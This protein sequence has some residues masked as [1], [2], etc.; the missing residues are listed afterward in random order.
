MN[1][2][3]CLGNFAKRW[4][5]L[6]GYHLQA[7]RPDPDRALPPVAYPLVGLVMG[8]TGIGMALIEVIGGIAGILVMA[9]PAALGSEK[10]RA[11]CIKMGQMLCVG[12]VMLIVYSVALIFGHT[13]GW[14]IWCCYTPPA[15]HEMG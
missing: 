1:H 12:V 13:I 14:A 6:G 3:E 4:S 8:S 2:L 11:W 15:A 7:I 9:I 10:A 5:P